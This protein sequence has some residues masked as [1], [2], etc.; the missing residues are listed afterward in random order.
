MPVEY[1]IR[2]TPALRANIFSGGMIAGKDGV[3]VVDAQINEK[4]ELILILSDGSTVNAGVIPASGGGY[5]IGYGLKLDSPTNTLSVD[6]ADAVEADNT[7]PITAAAVYV[8]VGNINAMLE[9]L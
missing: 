7:K 5:N 1:D 3:S 9:T 8:E 2:P 6:A 4:G